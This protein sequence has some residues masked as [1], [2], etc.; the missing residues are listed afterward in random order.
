MSLQ[1]RS[2]LRQE[3]VGRPIHAIF[4]R[5]RHKESGAAMF[6]VSSLVSRYVSP[7]IC[8]FALKA[9]PCRSLHFSNSRGLFFSCSNADAI[10]SAR[11]ISG[12]ATTEKHV[13][14]ARCEVTRTELESTRKCL[15]PAVR[16]YVPSSSCLAPVSHA[17]RSRYS[18]ARSAGVD[19][20]RILIACRSLRTGEHLAAGLKRAALGGPPIERRRSVLELE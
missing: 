16:W 19:P 17:I 18:A 1:F 13:D 3:I 5:S 11:G 8:P 6:Q 20:V 7:K 14:S 15:R 10:N 9:S 4:S 2:G 12:Y